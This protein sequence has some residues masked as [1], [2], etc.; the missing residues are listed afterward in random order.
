LTENINTLQVTPL[1]YVNTDRG[2]LTLIVT[3]T[4]E[5]I[6]GDLVTIDGIVGTTQLNGNQYYA[7]LMNAVTE[8]TI[9]YQPIK[10]F[11]DSLLAKPVTSKVLTSYVSGG[12]IWKSDSTHTINQSDLALD[13][14][15][16]LFVSVNGYR[17][18]NSK[19]KLKSNNK[20]NILE[21]INAGDVV[22]ITSMITYATP[23]QL[24]YVNRV[25]KNGEQTIYRA[26]SGVTTWLSKDLEVLDNQIYVQ[27]VT[28]LLDLV[29]ETVVATLV[30]NT[31]ACFVNYAVE[32]IKD[33]SIYNIS[34]LTQID[35]KNITLSIRN[36]R[37]VIYISK[38]ASDQ[39]NLKVSL[40]IGN[41][42][43]IDGEFITFK[44][45]NVETNTISGI[46][47]GANGSGA[48]KIHPE[49]TK[50]VGVKLTNTLFNYY[51]DRTWNSE[52][53]SAEG[54]PL[55]ISDSYPANFLQVGTN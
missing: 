4:P 8:D 20:I 48:R 32:T 14:V 7:R 53:Y 36:S 50:V 15:N 24:V 29:N 52:I 23:N 34:T 2:E 39:D 51:Y 28:K 37:P 3:T 44:K 19:I 30:N 45:V 25:D 9:T 43:N 49:Y 54:D 41:T 27:D 13:D 42:I 5:F 12:Y 47:R 31:V 10:L 38:G 55:Q 22:L 16:R 17:V 11:Y 46:T 26:N 40:R 35:P 18:D 21:T 1:V 6:T 33:I